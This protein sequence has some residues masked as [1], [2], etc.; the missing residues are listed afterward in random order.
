MLDHIKLLKELR[1][2]L[3]SSLNINIKK[4]K[5]N[6]IKIDNKIN[7]RISTTYEIDE[8]NKMKYI[9]VSYEKQVKK[10]SCINQFI[11]WYKNIYK[12]NNIA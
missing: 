4:V 9:E 7:M 3:M 5:E 8:K 1:V 6:C 12:N 11:K 2:K 10:I